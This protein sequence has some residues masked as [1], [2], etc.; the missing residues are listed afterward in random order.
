MTERTDADL[1]EIVTE[2]IRNAI[3]DNPDIWLADA[4]CGGRRALYD[5][6]KKDGYKQGWNDRAL[7][8]DEMVE[9]A[10]RVLWEFDDVK[11]V[12]GAAIVMALN[13]HTY[14]VTQIQWTRDD[15]RAVLE[16]ALG[17]APEGKSP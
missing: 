13:G 2:G 15:A 3:R 4:M 10:A 12:W 5:V 9:R 17:A 6:G 7:V 1:T 14:T 8:T 16:A 11:E